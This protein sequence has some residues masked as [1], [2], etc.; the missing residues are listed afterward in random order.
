MKPFFH[1]CL[2]LVI[3]L[4]AQ[5]ATAGST[6]TLQLA[7]SESATGRVVNVLED[8]ISL[9]QSIATVYQFD[10]YRQNFRKAGSKMRGKPDYSDAQNALGHVE[11]VLKSIVKKN[12]D[13]T[14]PPLRI[15][16]KTYKPV[17]PAAVKSASASFK[18][19]RS[20]AVTILLRADGHSKV[21]Y[22]RIAN[23]VGSDKLIIR[24]DIP[25]NRQTA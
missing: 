3:A 9:C 23:I 7:F 22:Q 15:N 11:S 12:L 4:A 6:P 25:I 14:A 19:A 24:S 16:G 21:H 20:E 17:K 5:P 1:L 18:R 13:K 8:G 10:C 2:S